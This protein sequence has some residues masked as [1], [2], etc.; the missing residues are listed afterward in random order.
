MEQTP[1]FIDAEMLFQAWISHEA[2]FQHKFTT[3]MQ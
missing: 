3:K 1:F 2:Q